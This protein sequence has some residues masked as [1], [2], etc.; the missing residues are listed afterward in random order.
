MMKKLYIRNDN[1]EDLVGYVHIKV[2]THHDK[3]ISDVLDTMEKITISDYTRDANVLKMIAPSPLQVNSA[4]W[5][6]TLLTGCDTSSSKKVFGLSKYLIDR[7]KAG[8]IE[9]AG[10]EWELYS[11]P[12]LPSDEQSLVCMYRRVEKGVR[13]HQQRQP[14]FLEMQSRAV[15]VKLI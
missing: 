2:S 5:Y 10:G 15:S 3:I 1:R 14:V 13:F 7:K 6:S 12:I 4:K 8:I 9:L 11:M